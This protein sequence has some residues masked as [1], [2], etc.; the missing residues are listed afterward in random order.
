MVEHHLHHQERKRD[1]NSPL[2]IS[3]I[4]P[5]VLKPSLSSLEDWWAA[6]PSSSKWFNPVTPGPCSRC[7]WRKQ[8]RWS[9]WT[10]AGPSCTQGVRLS[11]MLRDVMASPITSGAIN[12]EECLPRSPH[13]HRSEGLWRCVRACVCV[14]GVGGGWSLQ[15]CRGAHLKIGWRTMHQNPLATESQDIPPLIHLP[16]TE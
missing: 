6:F 16:E 8:P 9:R 15:L 11:Q 10:R 14:C 13:Q 7:V 5:Q 3:V 2:S 12:P 1:G 4:S